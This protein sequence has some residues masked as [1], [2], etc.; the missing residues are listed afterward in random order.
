METDPS[1]YYQEMGIYFLKYVFIGREIIM[2]R[3][4]FVFIWVLGADLT[5]IKRVYC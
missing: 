2:D 5:F 3:G 4:I 1:C